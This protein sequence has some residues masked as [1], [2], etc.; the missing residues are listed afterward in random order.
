MTLLIEGK[1]TM[2]LPSL[3]TLGDGAVCSKEAPSPQVSLDAKGCC[4]SLA[5]STE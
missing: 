2:L 5:S 3:G 4:L 1:K